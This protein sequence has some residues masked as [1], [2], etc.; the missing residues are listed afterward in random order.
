MTTCKKYKNEKI[1]LIVKMIF[2]KYPNERFIYQLWEKAFVDFNAFI[3]YWSACSPY[4]QRL[5][6]SNPV[7]GNQPL[8]LVK[9]VHL[10][11]SLHVF[12]VSVKWTPYLLND[13]LIALR[14]HMLGHMRQWYTKKW[15]HPKCIQSAVK[16][17]SRIGLH[18]L[19]ASITVNY[20]CIHNSAR[21]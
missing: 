11:L 5:E 21:L 9:A 16:S 3:V 14:G 20:V 17:C 18:I 1:C 7:R 8:L 2:F 13:C 10:Q 12:G 6:C 19:A 4:E 15:M